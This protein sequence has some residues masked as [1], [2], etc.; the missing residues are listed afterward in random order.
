MK[1]MWLIVVLSL[2]TAFSIQ[3][4]A[5]QDKEDEGINT[6]LECDHASIERTLLHGS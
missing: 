1:I 3:L 4:H 6:E 2:T 5:G